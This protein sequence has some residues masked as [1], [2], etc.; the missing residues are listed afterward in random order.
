MTH[1]EMIEVITAHKEG[2]QIEYSYRAGLGSERWQAVSS[3]T[4]LWAFDEIVYRVKPL[5]RVRWIVEGT[6]V[7]GSDF[8]WSYASE[9]QAASSVEVTK[10]GI[11]ADLYRP[12]TVMYRVEEKAE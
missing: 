5:P 10:A 8:I 11:Y 6:T 2:K 7:M 12:G 1:D 9:E 4:P 3:S